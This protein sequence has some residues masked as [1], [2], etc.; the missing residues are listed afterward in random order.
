MGERD[1]QVVALHQLPL[2]AS[3]L[4]VALIEGSLVWVARQMGHKDANITLSIYAH[5]FEQ[6][7]R[8]NAARDGL[9]AAFGKTVLSSAPN[10]A[11]NRPDLKAV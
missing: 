1:D 11:Q 9:D 8:S 10:R 3:Y 4:L 6:A 2:E 7:K 5:L